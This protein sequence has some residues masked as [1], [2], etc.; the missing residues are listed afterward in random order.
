MHPSSES[1]GDALWLREALPRHV[2]NARIWSFGYPSNESTPT[3][4]SDTA[5]KLLDAICQKVLTAEE[6]G[7]R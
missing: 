7:T 6:V 2:P 4:V 3:E 1:N 5:T